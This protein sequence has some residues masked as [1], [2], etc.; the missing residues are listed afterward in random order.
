MS[1]PPLDASIADTAGD[2]LPPPPGLEA[3]PAA[4]TLPTCPL[5]TG[6]D[7]YVD[8]TFPQGGN[9]SQICPFS[10]ITSATQ[11]V[12]APSPGGSAYKIHIQAGTYS[13][14]TNGETFPIDVATNV[15]LLGDP[16]S[17]TR[18]GTTIDGV[19]LFT[20]L[21]GARSANITVHV[22]GM[23]NYLTVTDS[24]GSADAIVLATYGQ[25]TVTTTTVDAA[26]SKN[27]IELDMTDGLTFTMS[28]QSET[29]NATDYGLWITSTGGAPNVIATDSSFH[30][31]GKDGVFAEHGTSLLFGAKASCLVVCSGIA[32]CSVP[33]QCSTC[34][35]VGADSFFCNTNYDVE[36][37]VALSAE[38]DMWNVAVPTCAATGPASFNS[39]MVQANCYQ[40]AAPGACP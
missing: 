35:T 3:G 13:V 15:Q 23:L 11:A 17:T 40:G 37:N 6:T 32:S 34:S 12:P 26:Q 31:N 21:A 33:G 25:P 9:G 20:Y 10:T 2:T 19:G 22:A 18:A 28:N 5:P 38:G 29:E 36:S 24:T 30:N 16:S 39:C 4:D 7:L 8:G 14:N 27:G 1:R